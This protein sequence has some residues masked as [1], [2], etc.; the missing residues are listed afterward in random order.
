MM[1]EL[2]EGDDRF[3]VTNVKAMEWIDFQQDKIAMDSSLLKLF[4]EGSTRPWVYQAREIEGQ[5]LLSQ[6]KDKS[7]FTAAKA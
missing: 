5:T 2:I 7:V 3:S 4:R 1:G 6:K